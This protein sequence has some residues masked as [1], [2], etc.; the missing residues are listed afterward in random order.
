VN[1]AAEVVCDAFPVRAIERVIGVQGHQAAAGS[2][3]STPPRQLGSMPPHSVFGAPNRR[4]PPVDC[5]GR[6]ESA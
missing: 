3:Q 6:V 1:V 4:K 5:F 2:A